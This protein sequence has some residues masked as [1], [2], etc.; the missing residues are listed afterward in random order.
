MEQRYSQLM[1]TFFQVLA[2]AIY[3]AIMG[4]CVWAF[5]AAYDEGWIVGLPIALAIGATR[6]FFFD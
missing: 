4:G 3:L 2:W 1:A 6:A 5:F